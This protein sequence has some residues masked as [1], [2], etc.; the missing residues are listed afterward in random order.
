MARIKLALAAALTVTTFTGCGLCPF[1]RQPAPVP[2]A[3]PAPCYPAEPCC[4]TGDCCSPG[5]QGMEYSSG[6]STPYPG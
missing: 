5:Y 6:Y 3:S 2:V 4:P 1:R